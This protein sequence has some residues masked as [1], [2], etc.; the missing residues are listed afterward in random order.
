LAVGG[1]GFAAGQTGD[2]NRVALVLKHQLVEEY[3]S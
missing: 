1:D 3:Q 2:V